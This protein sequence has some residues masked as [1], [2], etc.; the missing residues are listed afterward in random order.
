M[1]MHHERQCSRS[2]LFYTV[3]DE[4]FSVPHAVVAPTGTTTHVKRKHGM[5]LCYP[6]H[7]DPLLPLHVRYLQTWALLVS[8]GKSVQ[9]AQ[10]EAVIG[11]VPRYSTAKYE[12]GEEWEKSGAEGVNVAESMPAGL[13]TLRGPGAR[14]ER[15][16]ACFWQVAGIV[17]TAQGPMTA[18]TR[19][20][21]PSRSNLHASVSD[22]IFG[23]SSTHCG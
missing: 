8:D 14:A 11:A 19:D 17:Q 15:R 13:R 12:S 20:R 2:A 10:R 22:Q 4:L 3:T 16:K 21:A 7:L 9:L 1:M 6:V 5:L 23:P 18:C